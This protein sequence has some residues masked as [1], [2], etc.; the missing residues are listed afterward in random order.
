MSK[1]KQDTKKNAT[2]NSIKKYGPII[3]TSI[4]ALALGAVTG[5]VGLIVAG[6]VV[7]GVV[8]AQNAKAF[9]DELEKKAEPKIDRPLQFRDDIFEDNESMNGREGFQISND[10]HL[11]YK[12]YLMLG[13]GDQANLYYVNSEGFAR[14]MELKDGEKFKKYIQSQQELLKN[15]ETIAPNPVLNQMIQKYVVPD[16]LQT[17]R[18]STKKLVA[19]IGLA[20]AVAGVVAALPFVGIP[21]AGVL[22]IT[23]I[24][25]AIALAAPFVGRFIKNIFTKNKENKS[26]KAKSSINENPKKDTAEDTEALMN[27]TI[28][29]N[30]SNHKS[31]L[32]VIETIPHQMP[33]EG[34][35][36]SEPSLSPIQSPKPSM[37]LGIMDKVK[38][39]E[40]NPFKKVYEKETGREKESRIIQTKEDDD[41]GEGER[42]TG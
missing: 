32:H 39:S 30:S 14:K 41:D 15:P 20:I 2:L 16:K 38:H 34:R 4:A 11:S 28:M 5:G 10:E 42:P 12:S 29:E 6:V 7:A 37:E 22:A 24:G 36:L 8:Y 18:H 19:G 1:Q 21:I 3:A 25:L 40:T 13:K 35:A 27:K 23:G 33:V 31:Q 9:S 26:E 17:T